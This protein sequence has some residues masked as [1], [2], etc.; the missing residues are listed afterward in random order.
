MI[1]VQF[2][3]AEWAIMVQKAVALISWFNLMVLEL[4]YLSKI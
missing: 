3:R 4:E 2:Y 1:E